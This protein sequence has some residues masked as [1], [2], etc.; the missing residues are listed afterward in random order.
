ME[1]TKI[2]KDLHEIPRFLKLIRPYWR[3]IAEA[4]GVG[5]VITL[6]GIPAPYLTKILIDCTEKNFFVSLI[7]YN[8]VLY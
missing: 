8:N 2:R 4:L 6:L 1:K 3:F 5:I 7:G